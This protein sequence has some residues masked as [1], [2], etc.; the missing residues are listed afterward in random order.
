[1]LPAKREGTCKK[2]KKRLSLLTCRT[3]RVSGICFCHSGSYER[4]PALASRTKPKV[5]NRASAPTCGSGSG[6]TRKKK[7]AVWSVFG[8]VFELRSVGRIPGTKNVRHRL[9]HF[10][11]TAQELDKGSRLRDVQCVART[12]VLCWLSCSFE[13]VQG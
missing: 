2:K 10:G 1:M 9:S 8:R 6:F 4:F 7:V 11:K 12:V 5:Q 13:C 3:L